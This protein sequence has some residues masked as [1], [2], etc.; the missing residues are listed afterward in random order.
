MQLY[1]LYMKAYMHL[2]AQKWLDSES[3]SISTEDFDKISIQITHDCNLKKCVNTA[4][5]MVAVDCL[6]TNVLRTELLQHFLKFLITLAQVLFL[7]QKGYYVT[8]FKLKSWS[9]SSPDSAWK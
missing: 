1:A 4:W 8:P 3:L 9:Y 5:M 6:G 7:W 2:G